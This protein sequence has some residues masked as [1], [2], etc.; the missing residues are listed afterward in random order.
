MMFTVKYSELVLYLILLFFL[1]YLL[2]QRFCF[3][4]IWYR[5]QHIG[6]LKNKCMLTSY[7]VHS[8][9]T[10]TWILKLPQMFDIFKKNWSVAVICKISKYSLSYVPHVK[11]S[12]AAT[13]KCTCDISMC[14]I[15]RQWFIIYTLTLEYRI[16]NLTNFN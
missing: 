6:G 2:E 4:S 9:K 5:G 1:N 8:L 10:H 12:P 14:T 3:K 11:T 13:H 16:Q 7:Q 15:N